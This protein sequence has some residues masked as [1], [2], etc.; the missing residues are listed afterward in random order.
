MTRLKSFGIKIRGLAFILAVVS[1]TVFVVYYFAS[2]ANTTIGNNI[3]TSGTLTVG[4]LTI[5]S[6]QINAS[7]TATTTAANGFK[8]YAGC[9]ELPDGTCAASVSSSLFTDGGAT[10]YLTSLTDNLGIGTSTVGSAFMLGVHGSAIVSGNLSVANIT[11]T[12]TATVSGTLTVSGTGSSSIATALGVASTSPWGTFSVE[13]GEVNPSFVVSNNGSSTPSLFV[14]GVNQNGYVGIGTATPNQALT[15]IGNISNVMAS[16]T[17]GF[18]AV[19]F[20]GSI[21]ASNTPE[22]VFVQGR[23]AYVNNNVDNTLQIF[24]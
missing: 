19:K 7:S 20:V 18:S 10:S 21:A 24:D 5:L 3:S 14:G 12:G 11:A 15:V 17:P 1:A 6:G 16:S 4:G 23:Y 8:L 2:A 9:F 22:S 13:M